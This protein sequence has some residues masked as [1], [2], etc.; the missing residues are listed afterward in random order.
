V[1]SLKCPLKRLVGVWISVLAF[2]DLQVEGSALAVDQRRSRVEQL[3]SRATVTGESSAS[4]GTETNSTAAGLEPPA[5]WTMV[6]KLIPSFT[7]HGDDNSAL[8][9]TNVAF[10]VENLLPGAQDELTVADG[11]SQ[12]WPEQ[13]RL[14]VGVPVTVMPGLLVPVV[15]AGRDELVEKVRQ[16][17]L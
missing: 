8:A 6:L 13:G 7:N 3:L 10:Q 4:C 2:S 1:S 12:R 16:I 9:S 5:T 17:M 14:Q 15:T 11:H